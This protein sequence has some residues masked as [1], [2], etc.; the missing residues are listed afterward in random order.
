M[1]RHAL[2]ETDR[3]ANYVRSPFFDPQTWDIVGEGYF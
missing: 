2:H 3:V 1:L